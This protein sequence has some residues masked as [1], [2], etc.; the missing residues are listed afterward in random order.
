MDVMRKRA[1]ERDSY[2][3][4]DREERGEVSRKERKA[5]QASPIT[6]ERGH[7]NF[8]GD[9]KQGVSDHQLTFCLK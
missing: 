8:F 9:L 3:D 2:S 6:T 5:A 1:R 4:D 7:I